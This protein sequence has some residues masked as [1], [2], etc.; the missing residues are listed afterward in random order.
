M[1]KK[2]NN[3]S[4]FITLPTISTAYFA[5]QIGWFEDQNRELQVKIPKM[6]I[7]T[8]QKLNE[9]LQ[10]V[11]I[12]EVFT[13]SAKLGGISDVPLIVSDAMHKAM[14]EVSHRKTSNWSHGPVFRGPIFGKKISNHYNSSRLMIVEIRRIRSKYPLTAPLKNA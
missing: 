8:S 1:I 10:K 9:M 4:L 13:R 6:K 14:I 5:V 2:Y 12:T 3:L 7:E 11:G